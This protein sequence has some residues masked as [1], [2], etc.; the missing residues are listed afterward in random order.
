MTDDARISH[1]IDLLEQ[2][3]RE[4]LT[5]FVLLELEKPSGCEDWDLRAEELAERLQVF[6]EGTPLR[7]LVEVK[8]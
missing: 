3:C 7:V 8:Q 4:S 5:R 6:F 2:V 1:A